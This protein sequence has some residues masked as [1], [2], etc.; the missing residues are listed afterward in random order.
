MVLRTPQ[1]KEAD[2]RVLEHNAGPNHQPLQRKAN[3]MTTHGSAI[4][5]ESPHETETTTITISDALR[6]RAQAVIKDTS[7][8]PQW[9]TI[10]RYALEIN[11]PWLADLVRR[12]DAGETIMDTTELSP[13]IELNEDDSREEKINAL[14]EII[15][16]PG[17]RSA[18]ALFVLMG[19][20]ENSA[21]PKLLANTAKHFAFSRCGEANLFGMVDA[22]VA[23]VEGELLARE[24]LMS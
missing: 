6:R 4:A 5:L 11:D 15:C 17:D 13:T 7:I 21:H 2:R 9:R 16:R 19:T 22:Q 24:T 20:L 18:A 10:I 23:V 12:A 3:D 1:L 14:A 8:D